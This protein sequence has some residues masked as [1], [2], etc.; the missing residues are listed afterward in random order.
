ML[1]PKKA[2][3]HG[4]AASAWATKYA[5]C[6]QLFSSLVLQFCFV[7]AIS[8]LVHNVK[9]IHGQCYMLTASGN[10]FLIMSDAQETATSPYANCHSYFRTDF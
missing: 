6:D 10:L 1:S 8:D 5:F 4:I 7:V 3:M 2:Q 9:T